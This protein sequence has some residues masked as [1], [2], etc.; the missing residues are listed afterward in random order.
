MGFVN[1]GQAGNKCL[2]GIFREICR[3]DSDP[4]ERGVRRRLLHTAGQPVTHAGQHYYVEQSPDSKEGNTQAGPTVCCH[5]KA[6]C[7]PTPLSTV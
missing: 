3:R 4:A 7:Q 6:S 1:S 5:V 2:A